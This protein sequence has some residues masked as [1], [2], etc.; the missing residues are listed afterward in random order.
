[1]NAKAPE[2]KEISLDDIEISQKRLQDFVAKNS[3]IPSGRWGIILCYHG[4]TGCFRSAEDVS[5]VV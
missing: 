2:A 3:P 1:M 4:N 5:I